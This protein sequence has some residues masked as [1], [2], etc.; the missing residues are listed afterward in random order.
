MD[1]SDDQVALHV[2]DQGAGIAGEGREQLFTRFGRVPGSKMRAGHVGTGLG[3]YLGRLLAR[4]MHGEL[5]LEIDRTSRQ[6]LLPAA[7]AQ[8]WQRCRTGCAIG[9][10]LGSR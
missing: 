2:H 4:A 7:A 1:V 6:R 10:T 9:Q 5:D 3:L 8:F